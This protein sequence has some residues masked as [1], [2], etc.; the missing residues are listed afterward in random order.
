MIEDSMNRFPKNHRIKKDRRRCLF[1]SQIA[2]TI[3]PA[4]A[5]KENKV[6]MGSIKERETGKS[7]SKLS[8]VGCG[9]MIRL[10]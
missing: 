7:W 1:A 5:I 8:R 10:I 9:N 3:L 4:I 2:I 6:V